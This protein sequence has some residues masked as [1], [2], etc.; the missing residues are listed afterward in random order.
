MNSHD[1][2]LKAVKIVKKSQIFENDNFV[3]DSQIMQI[4][5]NVNES[6]N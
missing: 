2:E 4:A 6:Q 3:N 5:E 1:W